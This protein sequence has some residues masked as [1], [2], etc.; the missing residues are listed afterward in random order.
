[1]EENSRI[2]IGKFNEIFVRRITKLTIVC[3]AI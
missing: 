1:M 3:E 2:F